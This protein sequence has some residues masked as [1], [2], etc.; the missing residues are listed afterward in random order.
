[1]SFFVKNSEISGSVLASV[2]ILIL[3]MVFRVP[4]IIS[5]PVGVALFFGLWFYS[6]K[7]FDM[8]INRKAG[9]M[10]TAEIQK[11]IKLG[12]DKVEHIRKLTNQ[13]YGQDIRLRIL[14]I[15]ETTDRIFKN[16]EDDKADLNYASR[17][18]LYLDRF[19][20]AVDNY[21]KLCGT[22]EGIELLESSGNKDEFLDLIET[23]EKAF[24]DGLKN[25]LENDQMELRTVS[26]VLKR[27]MENAEIGR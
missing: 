1:M 8:E 22:P 25:Y 27:M 3:V 26:R 4:V 20:R 13:I 10:G 24:A 23:A 6:L 21:A 5:A 18:L 17:F 19:L 14:K 12:K 2:L 15:C 11:Q 7:Y 16:F 9:G